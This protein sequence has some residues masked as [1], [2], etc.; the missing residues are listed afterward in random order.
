MINE[1]KE[2]ISKTIDILIPTYNR[3]P[4]LANNL[5]LLQQQIITSNLDKRYQILVSNNCSTDET[6]AVIE[7]F[8]IKSR[9]DIK[10]FEQTENI[11]L[12][13][14]AIFLLKSSTANFVLYLGDDDYLPDGYLENLIEKVDRDEQLGVVIPGITTVDADGN[15]SVFREVSS[16]DIEMRPSFIAV[17]Q[18]SS[19]GHQLSGLLLRREGLYERYTANENLRN[20][21]PFIYFV[22]YNNQYFS[23]CYTPRHQ[24]LV[25]ISNSKDWRYDEIGLLGEIIK[26]YQILY[27]S[28]QIK[29]TASALVFIVKQRWRL[30][31][32]LWPSSYSKSINALKH[33]VGSPVP[34]SLLKFC[35]IFSIPFLYFAEFYAFVKRR[36]K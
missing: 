18:L 31:I 16:K 8:K 2:M 26:N 29:Q 7:N 35:V 14:N 13:R 32:N 21:Y 10:I 9:V 4:F 6:S 5:D 28:S 36:L 22:A 25:S 12:E 1:D 34:S 17:I 15:R 33:F 11:G 20:I 27:S 19:Y 30:R 3:A 24:V 23:S